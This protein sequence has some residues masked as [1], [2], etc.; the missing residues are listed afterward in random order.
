MLV[1]IKIYLNT[2]FENAKDLNF[3][4]INGN[5]ATIKKHETKVN[6]T[7]RIGSIKIIELIEVSNFRIKGNEAKKMALAG[8]GKPKNTSDWR[9][10]LLN[11][12]NLNAENTGIKNAKKGTN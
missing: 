11:L 12:A 3:R 6:T 4:A 2:F 7:N 1:Q 8:V 10:S 5:S 9:G